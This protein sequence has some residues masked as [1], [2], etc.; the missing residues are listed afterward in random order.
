[1]LKRPDVT[2]LVILSFIADTAMSLISSVIPPMPC[3]SSGA[4]C[5][6]RPAARIQYCGEYCQNCLFHI[7]MCFCKSNRRRLSYTPRKSMTAMLLPA[8][9]EIKEPVPA[10]R[11]PLPGFF[12]V[13]SELRSTCLLYISGSPVSIERNGMPKERKSASPAAVSHSITLPVLRVFVR[14]SFGQG[15]VFDATAHG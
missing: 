7:L 4:C 15:T 6:G 8:V 5:S 1:M 10:F 11:V 13:K 2:V 14:Q 9:P 3:A 12:T